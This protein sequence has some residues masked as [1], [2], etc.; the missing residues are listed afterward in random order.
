MSERTDRKILLVGAGT[1]GRHLSDLL[2]RERHEVV[3]IDRDKA[4]LESI[5]EALDVQTLQGDGVDPEILRKAGVEGAQLFLALTDSDETNLL[6]SFVA[7]KLGAS[8]CVARA[9]SPWWM[10]V[11]T[12][13]LRA[14][15]GIDLVINPE[16]LTAEEIVRFVDNPDALALASFAHG[17]VQLRTF[18]LDEESR[19]AGMRLKDIPLPAEAL[20]AVRS[21]EGVAV[22]PKG[23]AL[24]EAGDKL[25][26]LGVP[27]ILPEV[28]R[29]FH[30]PL[31]RVR[32]VV[33]VGGGHTGFFLAKTLER[34]RFQV[35]LID[36]RREVC[37]KLGERLDRVEI[38]C[39]DATD[40]GF[41]REERVGSADV[42]VAVTH[43]DES[44]LMSCLLA[45]ELGVGQTV[46]RIGRPDY[47]SLV[48]KFGVDKALSPRHVAAEKILALVARGRIRAIALLED[49]KIEVNEFVAQAGSPMI[50]KPLRMLDVPEGALIGA[51]VHRGGTTIARGSHAIE[52]G[53]TVVALGLREAMDK[54]ESRFDGG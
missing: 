10:E 35:K 21:R 18:V 36:V 1:V 25:T 7:K 47:A 33:V 40:M 44:N 24:L 48:Q 41:M 52:P 39:G 19:Y 14:T 43:D 29:M 22:V 42:F 51:I 38:V 9:R 16:N 15:L 12:L 26:V 2:A 31:D 46:A 49:G 28:Q 54:L 5:A 34:R 17:K 3:M 30:V 20:V 37:R 50:G 11:A 6:A 32:D 8:K 53:D 4:R 27:E 13:N 45:K 23:D